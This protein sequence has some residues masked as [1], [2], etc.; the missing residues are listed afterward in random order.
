MMTSV[1][2]DSQL[3]F[4]NSVSKFRTFI[5]FHCHSLLIFSQCFCVGTTFYF[6]QVYSPRSAMRTD[7]IIA[8]LERKL[9]SEKQEHLGCK[10]QEA[11]VYN[12][13][14]NDN[15]TE[16]VFP[17]RT[18]SQNSCRN[19]VRV[20]HKELDK[21]P[22]NEIWSEGQV[23]TCS[24]YFLLRPLSSI[25]QALPKSFVLRTQSLSHQRIW[26]NTS[27]PTSWTSDM[28]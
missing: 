22:G 17:F 2:I 19:K 12:N 16:N 5:M 15:K 20:W 25:W 10:I 21:R 4:L 11:R 3:S 7:H 26:I 24:H 28:L 9:D 27:W 23:D 14:N 6:S 13:G 18:A 8:C 1:S